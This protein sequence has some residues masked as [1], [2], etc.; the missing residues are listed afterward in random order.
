MI[1]LCEIYFSCT[2]ECANF[3]AFVYLNEGNS[4]GV[5]QSTTYT[6]P[7]AAIMV[8]SVDRYKFD[9]SNVPTKMHFSCASGGRF[10]RNSTI[11]LRAV[12]YQA[13]HFESMTKTFSSSLRSTCRLSVRCVRDLPGKYSHFFGDMNELRDGFDQCF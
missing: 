11:K 3:F 6:G 8:G 13:A 12:T 1:R 9:K 4:N 5:G 2:F 10:T 7:G